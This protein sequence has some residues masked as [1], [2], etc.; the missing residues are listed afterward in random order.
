MSDALVLGLD[1]STVCIGWSLFKFE[2]GSIYAFG[3]ILIPSNNLF[4]AMEYGRAEVLKIISSEEIVCA[5][6]EELNCF[7]GGNTTRMLCMMGGSIAM[8]L[9]DA[10]IHPNFINSSTIKQKFNAMPNSRENKLLAMERS[11]P[12]KFT[13]HL[14]LY[15]VNERLGLNL[16]FHSNKEKSDDDTGDGIAVGYTLLGLLREESTF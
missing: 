7:L 14:M 4:E 13:K 11:W 9:F 16:R 6:I 10:G 12:K 8:G 2:T 5:G 3:K 1:I 15:R